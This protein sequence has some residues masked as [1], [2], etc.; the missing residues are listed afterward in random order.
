M[1]SCTS[2]SPRGID[3]PTCRRWLLAWTH[4]ADLLAIARRRLRCRDD[5][6]DVVAEAMLRAV[7]YE[8]LDED[9]IGA[10]M[11]RVLI[12]LCADRG[13]DLAKEPRRREYAVLMALPAATPEEV[14]VERGIAVSACASLGQL[15]PSQRQAVLLRASGMSVSEVASQLDVGYK[16]AESLLSRGR[17]AVRAALVAGVAG[18]L[19]GMRP[20]RRASLAAGPVV[21]AAL[22]ALAVLTG[23]PAAPPEAVP[24]PA[25][26]PGPA[27]PTVVTARPA[28]LP[29]AGRALP[30]VAETE[31]RRPPLAAAPVRPAA[32]RSV[33]VVAPVVVDAGGVR[34]HSDG[35]TARSHEGEWQDRLVQ[36][37]LEGPAVTPEQVGCKPDEEPKDGPPAP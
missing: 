5:A 28:A 15:P 21:L 1:C 26:A 17:A 30:P 23:T 9:R 22:G 36:C 8:D 14:V 35:L 34:V 25:A 24:L 18:I 3:C 4:R 33:P 31:R 7:Q 32:P 27:A 10:W 6:D 29:P 20:S 11:T 2:Q 19:A 37:V 16:A 13:R 12:N